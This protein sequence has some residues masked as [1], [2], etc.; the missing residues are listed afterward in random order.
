MN[1]VDYCQVLSNGSVIVIVSPLLVPVLIDAAKSRL[2]NCRVEFMH[3]FEVQINDN[4]HI[5]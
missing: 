3:C 5:I 4:S 2:S 1:V